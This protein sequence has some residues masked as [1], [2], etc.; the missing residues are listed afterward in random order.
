MPRWGMVIDLEKCSG[1][2]A[3]AV[4]C[5]AE[6]NAPPGNAR[7]AAAGRL[8][9]WLQ[10]LPEMEGEYP[11]LKSG[12]HPM[13][14]QQCTHPPCTYVCPVSATYSNPQGVVA[15][16]YW[17]CIGCRYCVNACPYTMKWFNWKQPEWPGRL[18]D[19]TNPDVE[20][21][22]KGVTEKCCF[23]HHRLQRAKEQARMEK[24]PLRPDDYV[25][26][27]AEA[28]PT[29]AIVFGDLDDPESEL[30]RLARSPRALRYLE[31]LGTE[32]KVVYLKEK[33]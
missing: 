27:C 4:A 29:G 1:C 21:R 6:N 15:Q 33:K 5:A 30:S 3:C 26:A 2:Q 12:I 25:P 23:C 8:M 10:I 22:D 32:P 24:R 16:I 13:M 14:C 18:A 19:G 31:E 7:Q 9:R 28:C 17:R 11:Y 20:L